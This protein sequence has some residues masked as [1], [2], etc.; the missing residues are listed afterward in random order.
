MQS[1][2]I[3]GRR[4]FN[5]R[6]GNTYFSAYALVDGKP[7]GNIDYAYGYGGHYETEMFA[8]LERD[9]LLPFP[10]THH[11]HGTTEPAWVYCQSHGIAYSTN[12][13]DVQRK[14]DL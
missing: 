4:W 8:K 7:V 13:T 12:V 3:I 6:C 5:R 9:G 11:S 10:V 14:K 2:T 1:L